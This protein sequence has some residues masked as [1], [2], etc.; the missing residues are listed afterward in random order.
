MGPSRNSLLTLLFA[1]DNERQQVLGQPK[2]E[3]A[4]SVNSWIPIFEST[5]PNVW[6]HVGRLERPVATI[7]QNDKDDRRLELYTQ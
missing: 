4:I 3:R 2:Y 7:L 6:R 1:R 5:V